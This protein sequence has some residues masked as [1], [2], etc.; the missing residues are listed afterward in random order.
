MDFLKAAVEDWT[1][2]LCV[3][4]II[5]VHTLILCLQAN[6]DITSSTANYDA[7]LRGSSE[8]VQIPIWLESV[9]VGFSVGFVL[10]L[11]LRILAHEGAFFL[12]DEW[13]W[14]LFD[15]CVICAT[16]LEYLFP[17][18]EH[19]S[20]LR[21]IGHKPSRSLRVFRILRFAPSLYPLRFLLLACKNAMPALCWASLL[22]FILLTMSS[23]VFIGGAKAYIDSAGS[24]DAHVAG[25]RD[26]F[27]SVPRCMLTLF[28][29]FLGEV[30][31]KSVINLLAEVGWWY[32]LG[33]LAFILFTLLSVSNVIAGVFVAEAVEVAHQDREI[34][35]RGKLVEARRNMKELTGLF[36]KLDVHD[37]GRITLGDLEEQL[38]Q[39]E[40]Q[41]L[42]TF[43]RVDVSDTRS[44][45]QLLDA[46]N[47]GY[48]NREEFVV[49]C[50]RTGQFQE[51]SVEISQ[52]EA[53]AVYESILLALERIAEANTDLTVKLSRLEE[54]INGGE[55]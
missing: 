30:D 39:K 53:K 17:S 38:R 54:S 18:L 23:V 10:E 8:V 6:Y 3:A 22:I 35:V 43:F 31:F 16:M 9:D 32:W 21:I 27:G 51:L 2:N 1:F 41:D 34:R 37:S 13:C 14:N 44:F 33:Y 19:S 11:F 47:N 12:G 42:F 40:V 45:F 52:Q 49:A 55:F 15:L 20:I 46:D 26:H 29:T 28:V 36:E 25:L 4:V 5:F 48:V 24:P 7:R 50:L